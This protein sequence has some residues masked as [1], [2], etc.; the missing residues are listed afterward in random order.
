MRNG[1][2]AVACLVAALAAT[3]LITACGETKPAGPDWCPTVPGHQVECGVQSRP[4]V[5]DKPELGTVAVSYAL[6]RRSNTDAPAAGTIAPNP[7]GPGVPLIDHAAQATQLSAQLLTDHDLLLV[8]PRGTGLSSPLDCGADEAGYEIGTREYQQQTVARCAE[9]LGPRAAGYTSA[10]TADDFDAIRARLGIPKLVLYG[11]SYGTYL[12]PIYAERH[13]DTVQ[14]IVLSGA[15]PP[16]F[17]LLSRP[18]AEAVSLALQRICD[19]SRACDGATAVTDLRTVT[20]R[21]AAQPLPVAGRNPLVLSESK[22]ATL[23]FEVASTSVGADPTQPTLMGALPAALHSAANGDDTGLRQWAEQAGSEP[24]AENLDLFI[25][26]A[27]NDY[28]NL[29][30][31]QSPLNE[32]VQQYRDGLATAGADGVGAFS[33]EGFSAGMRDGGD[34]CIHWPAVTS[35]YPGRPVSALPNVPVLVLSGDLDAITP[36]ANGKRVAAGFPNATF[37]SVPNTGHV[38]DLEPSGCVTDLV[39]RFIRTG[40]P[41]PTACVD[42]IPPIAVTPVPR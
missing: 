37:L 26:V 6:V 32:R 12:M 21:L 23:A 7:G 27:C 14:S 18:S 22:F 10:A 5:T 24:T 41:G 4:L 15:Y 31:R 19:R 30:K 13:P 16:E 2:R 9:Q 20:Q 39:A 33:A 25:T 1:M 38:P 17:D 40:N 34:A 29:W 36:D 3:T 35:A 42:S 11:I 28:P 8:D